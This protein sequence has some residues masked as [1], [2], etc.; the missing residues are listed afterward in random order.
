MLIQATILSV[1]MNLMLAGPLGTTVEGGLDK[2]AIREVVR[3]NIGDV[4]EC[5]NAELVEDETAAGRV[6][7]SFVIQPDG[8]VTKTDVPESTM[9]ER[10][11]ACV[12]TAV[13]GWSFPTAGTSTSVVY[14]FEMSPG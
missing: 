7:V 1:F 6:V 8:K 5:Y 9:S 13:T 11:D 4:R 3:A 2:L 12:S 10:F 14:P